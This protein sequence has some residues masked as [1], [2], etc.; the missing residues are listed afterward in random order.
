MPW[1]GQE[2]RS[3]HAHALSPGQST[4]AASIA[5][6][7]LRNNPGKEGMAIATGIARAKGIGRQDGGATSFRQYPDAFLQGGSRQTGVYAPISRET[8]AERQMT[9]EQL[10]TTRPDAAASFVKPIPST[11][12]LPARM[13]PKS[14]ANK[15]AF[16]GSILQRAEGGSTGSATSSGMVAPGNIDLTRRPVVHNPDGS[17]STVRSITIGGEGDEPATL[18]PTVVGNRVVSNREAVDYYRKTGEHLGKFSSIGAADDYAQQL[19]E[20]QAQM[21]QGRAFGGAIPHLQGGGDT[22]SGFYSPTT[23]PSLSTVSP[24]SQNYI[25]RFQSMTSEQL[26][27]LVL[28]SGT[29]SSIGQLAQRVLQAKQMSPSTATPQMTQA[30]GQ[31]V[32]PQ[33]QALS[34]AS[35]SSIAFQPTLLQQ[36]PTQQTIQPAQGMTLQTPQQQQQPQQLT[37]G[38]AGGGSPLGMSMSMAEP[39]WTRSEARQTEYADSGFLKSGV[40]GRTDH[41]PQSPATDSYVVPA[42]VVSGIGEGNSIAGAH[43]LSL[44]M[45]TGPHGVPLPTAHRGP[46]PPHPSA[47]RLAADQSRGGASIRH[48]MHN[49]YAPPGTTPIMAAGGEFIIPGH[50]CRLLGRGDAKKGHQLLDK[51]VVHERKKI[52]KTM[53]RLPGPVK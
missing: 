8:A 4:K 1:T 5:N 44:A 30:A 10:Y 18:I 16:G 14:G 37:M 26:R 11:G 22:S 47:P 27:E 46:G 38:F 41:L 6:A 9:P 48:P 29:Q 53:Q 2:F 42:D 7:I 33:Q 23:T 13:P 31:T 39:W 19:H 49:G 28:R 15:M 12:V 51:W 43:I 52:I 17:I 3:R 21:Y 35:Q 40:P 34:P 50:I 45:G 36:T 24:I 20:D 32:Q 25:K